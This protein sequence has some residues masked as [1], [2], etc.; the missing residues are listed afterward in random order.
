MSDLPRLIVRTSLRTVTV[1]V[2]SYEEKGDKMLSVA[3]NKELVEFGWKYA[4]SNIPSAYLVGLVCGAKAKANGVKDAIVDFGLLRVLPKSKLYAAVKGV[5]DAGLNVRIGEN[6]LP[7]DPVVG[8]KRIADYAKL[9]LNDDKAA[10]DKQFSK[11]IKAGA[12]PENIEGEFAKVKE[13]ILKKK[14]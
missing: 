6:V 1:Q 10:Y 8:G 2:A 13:A 12:K 14:W 7:E 5:I 3:S 9:L 11:V 4:P